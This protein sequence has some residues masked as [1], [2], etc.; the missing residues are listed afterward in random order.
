MS[1]NEKRVLQIQAVAAVL[2]AALCFFLYDAMREPNVE[3]GDSAPSFKLVT[4]KGKQIS[5]KDFGGKV[6]V[7]N[8]WATWCPPCVEEMPSLQAMAEKLGPNGVVVLGVSV[9]ANEAAYQRFL[10]QT[11]VKFETSR[12]PEANISSSYGTF[13]YPET[14]VIDQ[15]GKVRQKYI[16]PRDWMSP[17]VLQSIQSLL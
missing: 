11:G 4:D 8:F 14:Y 13:K 12:D 1:N 2:L 5:T 7:L 10:K 6:L 17:D 16:G 15:N 9:D 3:T